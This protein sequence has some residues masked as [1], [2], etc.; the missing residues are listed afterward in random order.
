M[1]RSQLRGGPSAIRRRKWNWLGNTLRSVNRIEQAA[2][3]TGEDGDQRTRGKE[4]WERNV[5]SSVQL[6]GDG[7]TAQDRVTEV[8]G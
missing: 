5:D 1:T 6:E 8:D 2:Q 4:I 3:A 7:C